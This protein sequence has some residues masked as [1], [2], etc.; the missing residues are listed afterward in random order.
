[1]FEDGAEPARSA[2][3]HKN[4]LFLATIMLM[5]AAVSIGAV[6]S[7]LGVKAVRSAPLSVAG[8]V[9]LVASRPAVECAPAPSGMVAWWPGEA[10][11]VPAADSADA[12]AHFRANQ[13]VDACRRC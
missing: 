8:P 7:V 9:D 11:A 12:L 2:G 4:L 10:P 13:F 5:T 1:M 6:F 3:N